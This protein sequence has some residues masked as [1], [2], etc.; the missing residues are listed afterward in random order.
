MVTGIARIN[1]L[2]VG[3]IA[4]NQQ[5]TQHPEMRERT[6]PGGILYREGI[7]KISQF[8]RACNSDGIPILWLQDISGFDIGCE[9]EK[10]GLLGYGSNLLYTNSTNTVPMITVL[11]RKASGAGYYAMTGP[12]LRAVRAAL[13]AGHA[14]GG[15]GGPHAGHRR[16]PHQAR[17]QLPHHHGRPEGAGRRSRPA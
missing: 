9:A 17:R 16:L 6:R 10:H 1:G 4:N 8:S 7:A 11:L 12:T 14:A 15:H 3:I 13:D 2:Y 5:L